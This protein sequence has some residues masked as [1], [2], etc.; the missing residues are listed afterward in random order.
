MKYIKT[1][2]SL[3]LKEGEY[4]VVKSQA[5]KYFGLC[6]G[7][8]YSVYNGYYFYNN[9]YFVKYTLPD[10]H[11]FNDFFKQDEIIAHSKNKKDLEYYISSQKYNI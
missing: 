10:N 11:T 4:V 2:E 5:K 6:I 1:Y 9:G 3:D 8:I 7:I